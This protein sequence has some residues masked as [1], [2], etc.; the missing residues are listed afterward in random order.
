[1]MVRVGRGAGSFN[2]VALERPTY[3]I[4]ASYETYNPVIKIVYPRVVGLSL[5][6]RVVR[7]WV[8]SL[9]LEKPT[10]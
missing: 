3:Q 2:S 4:L 8:N 7:E 1:M 5:V 9:A 6:V 10:Y